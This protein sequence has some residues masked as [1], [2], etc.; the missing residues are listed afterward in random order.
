MLFRMTNGQKEEWNAGSSI[1]AAAR[2]RT[3]F[4]GQTVWLSTPPMWET[5][6]ARVRSYVS[7]RH[8]RRQTEAIG[9]AWEWCEVEPVGSPPRE[10]RDS[11]VHVRPNIPA[12]C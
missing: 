1:G 9:S 7:D 6:P 8:R 4:S 10:R 12:S 5:S 3:F 2:Y 11:L